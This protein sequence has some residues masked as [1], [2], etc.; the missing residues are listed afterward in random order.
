MHTLRLGLTGG[1][2][3]GKSTVA[4]QFAA[5][6]AYVIDAD[7]VSRSITASGGEAIDAIRDIFGPEMLT[8]KGALDR[9]AMRMR[10]FT[11]PYAKKQLEHIVHP[12]VAHAIHAK[13]QS[14]ESGGAKCIVFDIPLLV[15]S[16]HWR[17]NLHRILVVDCLESTQ[18]KRVCRRNA[19]PA[20]QV[21]Q[22]IISQAS[23]K[24][25]LAAADAVIFNDD[26]ELSVLDARVAEM[27][28]EFGL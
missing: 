21:V 28:C 18:I 1:I 4:A 8:D 11:D 26:I 9:D 5:H 6:G 17:K 22:I 14:A 20:D 27:A 2:G 12:L 19:L 7:A 25:R 23:R 16:P 3:S 10:V 13:A 15:E 24:Q